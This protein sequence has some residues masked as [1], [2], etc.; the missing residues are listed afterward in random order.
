[1]L[2]TAILALQCRKRVRDAKKLFDELKKEQKDVGKLKSMN[3]KLKEEMSS[4]RAMLAAQAKESA[5]SVEHE[6]ALSEKQKQIDDLEKRIAELEKQLLEAKSKVQKLELDLEK[7]IEEAV[8]DKDQI[9]HLQHSRRKSQFSGPDSPRGH[10]KSSSG[11]AN[12][13]FF[14]RHPATDTSAGPVPSDYVSPEMLAEHR[15]RV[16]R[17]EDELE[18]ERKMRREA[19]AEIIRLRAAANGVKLDPDMVNDLLSPQLD[20]ARSE[21]NSWTGDETPKNR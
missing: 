18:S 3:E 19:D 9:Q 17:L 13:G 20:S 11:E 7:Q 8:R 21:E 2:K 14:R 4:L 5:A 10:R 16:A 12:A 1:M 6:R 15:S